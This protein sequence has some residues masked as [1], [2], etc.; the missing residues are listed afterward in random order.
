MSNPP[1]YNALQFPAAAYFLYAAAGNPRRTQIRAK[2][3]SY[4]WKLPNNGE[5]QT[6]DF[7]PLFII[8][9]AF[10][11]SI[12]IFDLKI[13]PQITLKKPVQRAGQ[14]EGYGSAFLCPSKMRSQN[15][16]VRKYERIPQTPAE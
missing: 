6:H 16:I 14:I 9:K 15:K 2:R 5:T 11:Q 4:G 12:D 1:E 3:D 7:G 8:E 13:Q 10:R